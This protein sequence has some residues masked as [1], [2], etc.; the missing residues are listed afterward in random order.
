MWQSL[1]EQP[2]RNF[3]AFHSNA[4]EVAYDVGGM[5]SRTASGAVA[6]G[7]SLLL[8]VLAGTIAWRSIERF[9]TA[10]LFAQGRTPSDDLT[11]AHVNA[12]LEFA[13]WGIVLGLVLVVSFLLRWWHRSRRPNR[14]MA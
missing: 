12:R 3:S 7:A 5:K 6:L 10:Y 14:Q 4:Q 2:I 11:Q 1:R 13:A 8:I 9:Y